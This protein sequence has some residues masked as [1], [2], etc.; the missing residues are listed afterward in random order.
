MARPIRVWAPAART[1]RLAVGEQRSAMS[2]HEDGWWEVEADP[3]PGERYG[4]E[5]DGEGPFPDPRSRSQPDGVH[6]RSA[7]VERPAPGDR[8]DVPL[9]EAVFYEM[10]PGTFT[11]EGTFEAAIGKLD[12]LVS[13]GVTHVEVM[14]VAAFPGERGW[15]YDGVDLF[16]PHRA[17]G[18]P[19]GL[20]R[21]VAGAHARRLGVVLD[22]VYNHFGPDGN[23]LSR[24][25]PYTTD[26]YTTPWGEA[27]NLDGAGSDEV[28]RFFVDNARMWVEDYWIDGLR[29]D[30]VHALYDNSAFPFLAELAAELHALHPAPLLIAEDNRNDPR[31][32]WGAERGGMGLDGVGS[33][34]F[35]HALHV[36]LTGERD[37]Y[38][39]DYLGVADLAAALAKGFVYDGTRPSPF[40]GHR[41]GADPAGVEPHRLVISMQNHDQVGNRPLGKRI[42]HLVEPA[43]VKAGAAL[44]L[45]APHTPLLFMGEEW[46][47]S[48]PFQYF[49]DHRD[50]ALAAA[51]TEGRRSEFV[52]SIP[53]PA[54]VPDPQEEATFLRSRLMWEEVEE[55]GHRDMLEWYRKLLAL[56]R[57]AAGVRPAAGVRH[58]QDWVVMDRGALVVVTN[59]GGSGVEVEVAG[60]TGI[61]L[62]NGEVEVSGDRVR[63]GPH[64]TTVLGR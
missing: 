22:V 12:H 38:Y 29:I 27:V 8:V 36:A 32:V 53:D 42:G 4:F 51:V 56:R 26:A 16:A 24:F 50:P 14:P 34:D 62:S 41:W 35:H 45:L 15:G 39:A 20:A 3:A 21:F 48:T 18:G 6:G 55:A 40:R 19:D 7:V 47:A 64:S 59:L 60:A 57:S 1:V 10:H 28:R 9:E 61:A 49:T 37:G 25:G 58:G 30:A 33:D 44:L 52:G 43:A 2:R 17:Y 5:V 63:L 31:L 11:P 54:V 13:L 23:Y 46:N